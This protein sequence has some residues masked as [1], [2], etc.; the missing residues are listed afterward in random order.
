[1]TS[2]FLAVNILQTCPQAAAPYLGVSMVK[3]T[4]WLVWQH[5]GAGTLEEILIECDK[6]GSLKVLANLPAP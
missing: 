5:V 1:M 4:R 2:G 3:G 6:K